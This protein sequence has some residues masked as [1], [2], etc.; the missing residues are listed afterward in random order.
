MI[1]AGKSDGETDR[2]IEE[3]I[4]DAFWVDRDVYNE[5]PAHTE[6]DV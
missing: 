3:N 4:D 2:V 5:V 1:R 6:W